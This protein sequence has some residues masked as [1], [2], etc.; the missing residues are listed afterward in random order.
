MNNYAQV[1]PDQIQ[2]LIGN[3]TIVAIDTETTG[4]D[5]VR[6]RLVYVQF[7]V[8]KGHSFLLD[9]RKFIPELQAVLNNPSIGKVFHK[10]SFDVLFLMNAG[11]TVTNIAFDTKIAAYLLDNTQDNGLKDLTRKYLRVENVI[12]FNDIVPKA[13]R[14]KKG[15]PKP[16]ATTIEDAKIE[17]VVNYACADS[18]HTIQL[19]NLFAP[20]I[21]RQGFADLMAMELEVQDI[22]IQM[23]RNGCKLDLEKA[24]KIRIQVDKL[25]CEAEKKAKSYIGE[26]NLSSPKQLIEALY[27]K[28]G[29]P[30]VGVSKTTGS[31][32]TD[33]K[34]L[35]F[36]KH[37][38]PVIEHLLEYAKY[39]KL[40]G[41]YLEP[42]PAIVDQNDC[43]HGSFN[44]TVTDTGRL[45]SSG[46]NLQ[47]IPVKTALGKDFRK[48]FISRFKGGKLLVADYSQIE[49][50]ILAHLSQDK[51]LL[52]ALADGVD[53]HALTASLLLGVKLKNVTKEQRTIGKT[54]NFGILFG[55]GA[56]KLS[57]DAHISLAT[58][59]TYLETFFKKYKGVA[60]FKEAQ[61]QKVEKCGYVETILGRRLYIPKWKFAGTRAINYPV[62]GS[63]ADVVKK[64][65]ITVARK[66]KEE[67]YK[68]LLILQVHDELVWDVVPEEQDLLKIIVPQL[69]DN[70]VKITGELPADVKLVDSWG[71]MKD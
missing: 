39:S 32:S 30:V 3:A 23:V 69:M 10:A 59:Q 61:I 47:N 19:N 4:L 55:E 36:L 14:A 13:A 63:A 15:Q 17:D 29:L 64:A 24:D 35:T 60:E 41:T 62:Q 26:V 37:E 40:L 8:E 49:V 42:L 5:W 58:A 22:L 50:R 6:D 52:K 46:P 65:M 11:Y 12:E 31:P 57:I 54:F 71:E 38:H 66:F 51:L 20:E 45:S 70:V 1:K 9:A 2:S 53:T 68:S 28:L 44:Q 25:Q 43:L 33:E 18:D 56:E 34:C 67:A 16:P 27:V 21:Q 48:C 7:S